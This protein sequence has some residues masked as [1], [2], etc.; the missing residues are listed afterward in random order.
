MATGLYLSG[1]RAPGGAHG[2][3]GPDSRRSLRVS[4]AADAVDARGPRGDLACF[5]DDGEEARG[6]CSHPNSFEKKGPFDGGGGEDPRTDCAP[7]AE[8]HPIEHDGDRVEADHRRAVEARLLGVQLEVV[9]QAKLIRTSVGLEDA[10]FAKTH[11]THIRMLG[12]RLFDLR[13]WLQ[14]I[15]LLCK[16]EDRQE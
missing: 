12:F 8:T 14:S 10:E 11:L 9:L 2:P 4:F 3:H 5:G 13:R 7:R 15:K 16:Y 6:S 1:H